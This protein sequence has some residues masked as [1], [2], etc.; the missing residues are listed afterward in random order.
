MLSG[1]CRQ[2]CG[3]AGAS[4]WLPWLTDGEVP[5]Q[6]PHP[7]SCFHLDLPTSG[8]GR[9]EMRFTAWHLASP[10]L[11]LRVGFLPFAK[12]RFGQPGDVPGTG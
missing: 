4:R 7:W 12:R 11:H 10:P 5:E 6:H 8:L 3:P 1:Q 9:E 2:G